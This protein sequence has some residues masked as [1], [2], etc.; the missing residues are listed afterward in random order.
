M[1]TLHGEN[2]LVTDVL[3][4]KNLKYKKYAS[5]YL[6]LETK[7][8]IIEGVLSIIEYLDERFP[9]PQLITGDLEDQWRLKLSAK[10]L[11]EHP[12][13]CEEAVQYAN[14]FITGS[15]VT[16]L[17]LITANNTKNNRY[18]EQIRR[19]VNAT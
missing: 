12:E 5:D 4:V 1:L 16:I 6:Y 19:I 10:I 11:I 9:V 13:K 3:R 14:P 8:L 2:K 17:D 15:T 18:K 7:E